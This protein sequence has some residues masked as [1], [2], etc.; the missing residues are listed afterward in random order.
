MRDLA[1]EIEKL[2]EY[3]NVIVVST[4]L[5]GTIRRE[6]RPLLG[7]HTRLCYN[8]F[9]IAMGTVIP[10]FLHPEFVL[11]GVDDPEAAAAAEAFYRTIHGETFY[12]TSIENAE[13]IKVLYNT[14]I[15]TKIAFANTAMEICHR[16]PGTDVDNVISALFLGRDRIISPSYM[17]GGMGDG[18]GCH[19]RDNIALSFLARKL[20]MSFDWFSNIMLQRERQTDWLADL[21]EEH[22][23]GRPICVLGKA[24][25]PSC[26][27]DTGSPAL[28]L[29]NILEERG[30]S[31]VR[32]D[33][34]FD[35]A[36]A[37]PTDKAYCYFIGTRH[38][39]FRVFPYAPGSVVLDPWRY[40]ED[41]P[42]V[43]V[44]RIGVGQPV[45]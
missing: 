7:P 26:S 43:K 34:H 19:P 11:F 6:I 15:S 30:Y 17:S 21:V 22:A 28:L 44:V 29:G 41:R 13:L 31:V 23:E 2:G 1:E 18:G 35:S 37:A 42:G 33:P 45:T 25:K 14:F 39:E 3:R 12:K 5:P 9:F 32:Y 40:I 16:M 36:G 24:F 38:P 10:D 8:P 4:V 20:G 27:I